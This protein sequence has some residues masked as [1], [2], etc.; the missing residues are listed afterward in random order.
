MTLASYSPASEQ[1]LL[2][3]GLGDSTTAGTPRFRS[4]R[5]NPPDG[6]G[7]RKSQYAYWMMKEHPEWNVVNQGIPAERSDQIM[8]RF[9]TDVAALQPAYVIVL[10]GINDLYQ[11]YSAEFVIKNL[12]TIYKKARDTKIRVIACTALPYNDMPPAVRKEWLS[13]N[14]WIEENARK[15]KYVFC[16]TAA[17]LTDANG[18]LMTTKDGYH[19]DVEGY[20]KMGE[21]IA[22]ELSLRLRASQ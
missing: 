7:D 3:V 14:R 2:I 10:A 21:L 19:P 17:L 1:S 18:R 13:L 22:R 9:E 12:K 8:A 16:D 15:E 4:P 20:K 5:E 6:W 11:G